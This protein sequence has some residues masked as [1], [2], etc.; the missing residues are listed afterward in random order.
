MRILALLLLISIFAVTFQLTMK[1]HVQA[2]PTIDLAKA[3]HPH[4]HS[5]VEDESSFS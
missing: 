2:Q 1:G 4:P 5:T 3:I